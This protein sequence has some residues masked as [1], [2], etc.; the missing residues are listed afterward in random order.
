MG[1]LKCQG[2]VVTRN[3]TRAARFLVGMNESTKVVNTPIGDVL[4]V[5]NGAA[6]T[7]LVLPGSWTCP[8]QRPDAILEEAA[9]QLEAY[10][11]RQLQDF[12]LPLAPRGTPFQ[13]NV[14]QALQE[15]PYGT[16][17]SYSV[18]AQ[19]IGK[20]GA[21][22]AVGLAN[23]SNP[24]AIIIPCHRVIGASGTLVGYGGG[25]PRK[26]W[27]LDLEAGSSTLFEPIGNEQQVASAYRR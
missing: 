2:S 13:R 20:P 1:R 21:A 6:V 24:I 8:T 15:I 7:E 11:V 10:F 17:T 26:R 9:R 12:D 4:L 14:W 23:G 3:R 27:L 5:G 18:L 19:R 16:T 25:L 22:R